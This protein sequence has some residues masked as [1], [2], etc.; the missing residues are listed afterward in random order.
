MNLIYLGL[1]TDRIPILAMFTP[2]HIGGHVPAIPFG[3]VFDMPRLRKS[4]QRPVLEWREVKND[5]S[6]DVELLGCWNTWESVQFNEHFPR[7]SVIP[8]MLSLGCLSHLS[9]DLY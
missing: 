5:E 7:R 2:S 8:S 3:E 1:I 9:V 6:T 4:L